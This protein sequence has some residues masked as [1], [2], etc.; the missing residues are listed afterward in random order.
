MV[1]APTV[2]ADEVV[3]DTVRD[4]MSFHVSQAAIAAAT[5][6]VIACPPRNEIK[7]VWDRV[8]EL[9]LAAARRTI[10]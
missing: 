10:R 6:V 3:W 5:G 9:I 8:A 4:V 7:P 1:L 2:D